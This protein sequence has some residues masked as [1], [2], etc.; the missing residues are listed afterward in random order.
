VR[1]SRTLSHHVEG[2]CD[3]SRARDIAFHE[4]QAKQGGR[5]ALQGRIVEVIKTVEDH[6]AVTARSQRLRK[7]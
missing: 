3:I 2:A 7:V 6:H 1:H 4:L 5:G